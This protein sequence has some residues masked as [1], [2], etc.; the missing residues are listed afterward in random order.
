MATDNRKTI[1]I[2][3]GHDCMRRG[4]LELVQLFQESLGQQGTAT[5]KGVKRVGCNG[6]CGKGPVVT[7][8]PDNITY[9]NVQ[10]KHVDK[11][12][13]SI[14]QGQPYAK[15]MDDS[16]QKFH[17]GQFKVAMRNVGII[18]PVQMQ[19]Y[20]DRD[21]YKGLRNALEM[22]PA[23]VVREIE[24][25]GL[26][27]RGGAGFPT[28]RKLYLCRR[29]KDDTKYIICN[30]NESDPAVYK[31]ETLLEGDPHSVLEGM[32]IAAYAVGAKQGYFYIRDNYSFARQ[33]IGKAI[34]D[35]R[36]AGYLGTNIMGK[37]FSFDCKVIISE[38]KFIL[39]ET[40]A[41]IADIEG[42]PA[43]PHP[44]Y[45]HTSESGLRGKP[46]VIINTETMA[47]IPTIL[48]QGADAY[49]QIGTTGSTGTKMIDLDGCVENEGI[50]EVPM[51]TT[52]R[53]IVYDIGGGIKNKKH[54]KAVQVGGPMGGFFPESQLDVPLDFDVMSGLGATMSG[55]DFFVFDDHTCM[56]NMTRRYVAFLAEQSCGQ[57]TPCRDGIRWM[58]K[59]LDDICHGY[60]RPGYVELLETMATTISDTAMC[61]FGHNA[62]RPVLTAIRYFREEFNQHITESFCRAGVCKTLSAYVITPD[63]CIGCGL[64]KRVCPVSAITGDKKQPHFL[65]VD[66]CIVCGNCIDKCRFEAIKVVHPTA[67]ILVHVED[68][69]SAGQADG[70]AGR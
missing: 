61:G 6:L 59:I 39:G 32:I 5:V 50:V 42:K 1:V 34:K 28:G 53:K 21:G 30:G 57:C 45:K 51:G 40:S 70:K 20:L 52:L 43:K 66:K 3:C 44:R 14:E 33:M 25:S 64:C 36:S 49:M 19:D 4:A 13:E 11:I 2:C 31:D 58:L 41:L 17:D 8:L 65:D 48:H 22:E 15:L 9:Y 56:V 37:D 63:K 26:R 62:A 46:T 35:A 67:K 16:A 55:G 24:M 54:F 12:I 47:N 68:A 18:D 38:G 69:E 7:I 60:G 29:A 27:G 10:P 23:D